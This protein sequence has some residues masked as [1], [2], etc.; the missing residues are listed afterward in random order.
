MLAN[1]CSY[2]HRGVGSNLRSF[3]FFSNVVIKHS[4]INGNEA[5][6]A[7]QANFLLFTPDLG[8]KV[9]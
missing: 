3:F 4:E 1:I 9:K 8:Q 6:N 5:K 2:T 7:M